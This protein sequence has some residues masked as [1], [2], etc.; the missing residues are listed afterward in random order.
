MVTGSIETVQ[1]PTPLSACRHSGQFAFFVLLTIK[2]W[3]A[4]CHCK[5]D[6]WRSACKQS[7]VAVL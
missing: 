1:M 3:N 6:V 4:L 7:R 5:G 2:P